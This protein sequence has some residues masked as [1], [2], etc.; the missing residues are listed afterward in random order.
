MQIIDKIINRIFAKEVGRDNF[1]NRYFKS[2]FKDYLG[3][4]RRIVEYKGLADPTKI[5]SSWYSWIH[6][7][8]DEIPINNAN[9]YSWQKARQQNNTG[10]KQRET[11]RWIK[12]EHYIKWHPNNE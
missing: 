3:R 2:N 4:K 12:K 7:L 8:N 10:T 9:R 5:E 1:G 11:L 6:F